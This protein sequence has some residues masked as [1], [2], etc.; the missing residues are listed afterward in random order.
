MGWDPILV[1]LHQGLEMSIS[2][3]TTFRILTRSRRWQVF[4]MYYSITVEI[5]CSDEFGGL[6]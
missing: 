3:D 1:Y 4:T 2:E 6:Y 5:T